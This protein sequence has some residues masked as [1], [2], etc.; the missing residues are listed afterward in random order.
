MIRSVLVF[1][2]EMREI[3]GEKIEKLCFGNFEMLTKRSTR[4]YLE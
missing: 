1:F 2:V 4:R 3:W